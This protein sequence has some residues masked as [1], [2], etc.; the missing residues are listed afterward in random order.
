M[1]NTWL[2]DSA[3]KQLFMQKDLQVSR[4]TATKYLDDIVKIGLL[5]K[6]K[7]GKENYYVNVNL[8]SLFVSQGEY[9]NVVDTI[10]TTI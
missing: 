6:V 1:S 2:N 9:N 7:K 3:P 10:V 4:N 5:E 8:M